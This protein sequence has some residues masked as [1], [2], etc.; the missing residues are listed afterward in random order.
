MNPDLDYD[1]EEAEIRAT[2]YLGDEYSDF[3]MVPAIPSPHM[4]SKNPSRVQKDIDRISELPTDERKAEIRALIEWQNKAIRILQD[5]A[6]QNDPDKLNSDLKLNH[7]L[8]GNNADILDWL[9]F[10][11]DIAHTSQKILEREE[12]AIRELARHDPGAYAMLYYFR[13]QWTS[14]LNIDVFSKNILEDVY[15]WTHFGKNANPDHIEWFNFIEHQF[16]V[17]GL[18]LPRVSYNFSDYMDSISGLDLP[19]SPNK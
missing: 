2:Y 6:V 5:W 7:Q 9:K 3:Y 8:Y 11:T 14:V 12:V 18:N 15:G 1:T 17:V 16:P 13:S 19:A 10:L 4:S